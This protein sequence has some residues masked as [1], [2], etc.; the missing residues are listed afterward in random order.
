MKAVLVSPMPSAIVTQST[1]NM[2]KPSSSSNKVDPSDLV[3]IGDRY[4]SHVP[5]FL[6]TYES[7]DKNVHNFFVDSGAS[8][9]IIP[10]DVCTKLNITSQKYAVDIV[11][12]ARTRIEF[13]GEITLVSIRLSSSP[14]V[15]QII[16]IL[17]ANIPKFY[18]LFLSREWSEKLHG[19]FATDWSHMWFPHNGKPKQIRVD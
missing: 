12:L 6:I 7:F 13:L 19:Y 5:P 9:N 10:R 16:Y 11:K 18:G 1:Y 8:S 3:L 4:I 2:G 15:S 17:V 14:K